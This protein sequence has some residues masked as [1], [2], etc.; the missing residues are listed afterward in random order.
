MKT[1]PFQGL[2]ECRRVQTG[3][4]LDEIDRVLP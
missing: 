1:S 2:G 3:S 4:F